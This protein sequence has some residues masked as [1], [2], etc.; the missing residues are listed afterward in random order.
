MV[1]HG[2]APYEH[3]PEA[4]ESY[5]V[6][7][8]NDKGEQRTLWGVDLKRALQEAQPAIGDKIG[9]QHEGATPVTLPDG[10]QTQRN[11]WRVVEG[12]ELA[13]SQLEHRLSRSGAKE[14]TLD[15]VRDF[16][17]RRGIAEAFGFKSEI[18]I[19]RERAERQ[20]LGRGSSRGSSA[21]AE[22]HG[23]REASSARAGDHAP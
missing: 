4:R 20:T 2:T 6:T 9:L 17:E 1:D 21:P 19:P 18:E 14:T 11:S 8:E 12:G 5:F 3:N 10:T 16:A 23:D 22:P 13:Y 15:Y 7:L